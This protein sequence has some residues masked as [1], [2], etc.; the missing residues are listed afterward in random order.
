MDKKNKLLIVGLAVI[1]VISIIITLPVVTSHYV[2][3]H[4]WYAQPKCTGCHKDIVDEINSGDEVYLDYYP[5]PPR[6]FHRATNNEACLLCHRTGNLTKVYEQVDPKGSC[7]NCHTGEWN[8][9]PSRRCFGCHN[10]DPYYSMHGHNVSVH[11]CMDCHFNPS[12]W[13]HCQFH[14]T[15]FYP[16]ELNGSIKM[17]YAVLWLKN[18]S[19]HQLMAN[20][21]GC[22]ACHLAIDVNLTFSGIHTGIK[23]EYNETADNVSFIPYG[24]KTIFIFVS[25]DSKG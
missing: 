16:H 9:D 3:S 7:K 14:P 17:Y 11:E 8:G 20:Q 18:G 2:G 21:K 24:S 25:G 19:A 15:T 13:N 1:V 23:I 22:L 6:E 12:M 10:A 5:A 4:T